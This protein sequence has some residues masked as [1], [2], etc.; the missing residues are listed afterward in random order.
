MRT[1]RRRSRALLPRLCP[2]FPFLS[3]LSLSLILAFP[4]QA[5]ALLPATTIRHKASFSTL[6]RGIVRGKVSRSFPRTPC[7]TSSLRPPFA[8]HPL[9]FI[10]LITFSRCSPSSSHSTRSFSGA[11]LRR[12]LSHLADSYS[13]RLCVI[14]VHVCI[15]RVSRERKA[16]FS[17]CSLC[18]SDLRILGW[19]SRAKSTA[20]GRFCHEW[21]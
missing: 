11:H 2:P 17:I 14:V 3:P 19:V 16:A 15:Y 21:R 12:S 8:T 10:P 4:R 7:Q 1:D 20:H 5:R 6:R 13:F 9:S 18:A